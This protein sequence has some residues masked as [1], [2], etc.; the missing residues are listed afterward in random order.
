MILYGG[1]RNNVKKLFYQSII[2]FS[3]VFSLITIQQVKGEDEPI[4]N[5]EKLT[6]YEEA[7]GYYYGR[8]RPFDYKRMLSCAELASQEGSMEADFLLA[9]LYI[10]G[11]RRECL[12][13]AKRAFNYI[14]KHEN[15][16]S[17]EKNILLA[18]LLLMQ[19]DN[20]LRH[21]TE[22]LNEIWSHL[23]IAQE[24]GNAEAVYLIAVL[25]YKGLGCEADKLAALELMQK[26]ADFQ[27]REAIRSLGLIYI[28]DERE[29]EGIPLLTL[30]AEKGDAE[31]L[32]YLGMIYGD[33]LYGQ[34]ADFHRA[35]AYMR[36]A[37][38]RGYI[39]AQYVLG[40]CLIE[41][42]RGYRDELEGWFWMREAYHNDDFNAEEYIRDRENL[43][44]NSL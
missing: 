5:V 18:R 23:R 28:A 2:F 10:D 31:A 27:N 29:E 25:T 6:L 41:G 13:D 14:N 12:A 20:D 36:E 15:T 16:N 33:E 8:I 3:Y 35:L 11:G 9:R 26:S 40:K 19:T 44:K 22:A 43:L 34:T 37:A 42:I 24:A 21:N 17:V 1:M 4:T 30:A 38:S 32:F 39:K 7:M